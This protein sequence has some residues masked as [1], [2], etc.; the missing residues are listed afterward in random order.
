MIDALNLCGP[1]NL[2]LIHIDEPRELAY[3][4]HVLDV[5]EDQLREIVASVGA[6]AVD[7]RRQVTRMRHAERLRRA[8]PPKPPTPPTDRHVHSSGEESVFALVICCAAAVATTF[9]A[10]AY[11]PKPSDEWAA[12]QRQHGCKAAKNSDPTIEQL[13]CPDGR[14]VTRGKLADAA[15]STAARPMR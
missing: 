15:D 1:A 8:H 13:R 14:M 4:A 7:V 9:G 11:K 12:Y 2:E 3:W 10:L 6:R 5:S